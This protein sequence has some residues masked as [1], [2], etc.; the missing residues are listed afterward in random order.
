MWYF[1]SYGARRSSCDTG[2]R[3]HG[4]T[5]RGR[6]GD[7]E[8]EPAGF[9]ARAVDELEVVILAALTPSPPRPLL[10]SPC[11]LVPRPKLMGFLAPLGLAGALLALPVL[12]MYFLRLRR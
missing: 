3:G 12:A 11:P 9:L 10:L 4:G 8:R 5:G 1:A 7:W 2:T 6:G